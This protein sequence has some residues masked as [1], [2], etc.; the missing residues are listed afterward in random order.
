MKQQEQEHLH[1][2]LMIVLLLL[3]L[4]ILE[5]VSQGLEEEKIVDEESDSYDV[6]PLKEVGY[7]DC[8]D[9]DYLKKKKDHQ[10]TL[11]RCFLE[12]KRE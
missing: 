8:E 9:Y 2:F 5:M 4:I 1:C 12:K 7:D 3:L 10:K 11:G 6:H